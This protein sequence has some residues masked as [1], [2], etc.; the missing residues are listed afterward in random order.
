MRP[1]VL[2]LVGTDKLA[3]VTPINWRGGSHATN[4][5]GSRRVS[6]P[7][8]SVAATMRPYGCTFPASCRQ[9]LA[10]H[11]QTSTPSTIQRTRSSTGS[12]GEKGRLPTGPHA[13]LGPMI[14]PTVSWLGRNRSSTP[15]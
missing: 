14:R 3:D 7:A 11:L 6:P 15:S 4:V 1:R 13:P 12:A 9:E 2:G 10:R 8:L 5:F